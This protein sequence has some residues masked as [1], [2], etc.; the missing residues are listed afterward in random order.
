MRAPESLRGRS[1]PCP[2]CQTT[3]HIPAADGGAIDLLNLDPLA[4]GP[5]SAGVPAGGLLHQ[6]LGRHASAEDASHTWVMIAAV[7]GGGVVVLLLLAM[8]VTS[9]FG[10][11]KRVAITPEPKPAPA[12]RPALKGGATAPSAPAPAPVIPPPPAAPLPAP[13]LP[14]PP[15]APTA[16]PESKAAAPQNSLSPFGSKTG[17][18]FQEVEGV[19]LARLPAA[20]QAWHGQPGVKLS[21]LNPAGP[22]GNPVAHLSWMTELLPFLGHDAIY[23]KL[24]RSKPLSEAT[25]F[26]VGAEVIAEFQNPADGRTRFEGFPFDGMALTHFAGMSGVEDARNVVAAKLPRSD[27]RAGVFGYDAVAR[28]DAITD[29][30]SQT[31]MV[32]GSGRLANPWIMGGGAT[33][34]GAR[35]PL[36]HDVSGLGSKGLSSPGTIVVMA[37]GSVRQISANVD[38]RVFRA[39]CTIHGAE[40]V[41][42]ETA[43]PPFSL[44]SL[45]P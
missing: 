11:R 6:P 9:S 5:L 25:N 23:H 30:T 37:D 8:I 34:R 40:S 41:D 16:S 19:P 29:G 3:L 45:Q 21:G 33:I 36:F 4:L 38:P 22:E 20:L 42:L 1:V 39:M 14:A 18:G 7:G 12:L 17:G 35:E 2:A 27:P 10:G 26:E 13:P 43:A 44:E 31:I 28:F 24:D 32:V 15:V